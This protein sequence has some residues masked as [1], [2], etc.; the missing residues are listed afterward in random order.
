MLETRRLAYFVAAC[1][2]LHLAKAAEEVG[3]AQSTLSMA[4][5]SLE[6]D[7]S[8]TLFASGRTGLIPTSEATWLYQAATP[9]LHAESFA[10][11]FAGLSEAPK[12]TRIAIHP[13]LTFAF[14]RFAKA[15]SY[16]IEALQPRFP[17]TLF[18]LQWRP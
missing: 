5:K 1:Q 13:R 18:E 6:E 14:G 11:S 3:V 2:H 10:R 4:L 16:V 9:V 8:L 7:L 12:A 15:V 17:S